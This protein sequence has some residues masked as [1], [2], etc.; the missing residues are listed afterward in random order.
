[1]R[2]TPCAPIAMHPVSDAGGCE[3]MLKR[4]LDGSEYRH[5]NRRPTPTPRAIIRAVVP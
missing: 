2:S 5:I 1:M 3:G 4:A